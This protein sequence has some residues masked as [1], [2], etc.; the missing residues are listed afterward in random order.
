[1][2]ATAL[3]IVAL[4]AFACGPAVLADHSCAEGAEGLTYETFGRDFLDRSCQ[5]CHGAVGPDRKGAPTA[6]DFGT[7]A[8]AAA[9]RERIFAR[10]ALDNTTM[11]PGPDDPSEEER[12]K[13]ADWLAC[14]AP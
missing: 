4:M 3:F 12:Q 5:R 6:F 11:P 1:M 13:L 8:S 9:W 2:K 10:A 14:G 7:Q